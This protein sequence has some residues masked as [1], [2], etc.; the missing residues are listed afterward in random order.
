M[1]KKVFSMFLSVLMLMSVVAVM[2]A[3]A[4]AAQKGDIYNGQFHGTLELK[5]SPTL[6]VGEKISG[7]IDVNGYPLRFAGDASYFG[8]WR[9]KTLDSK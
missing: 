1:K 8:Y 2:P 7:A 5:M 4:T 3:S 9:D 6:R